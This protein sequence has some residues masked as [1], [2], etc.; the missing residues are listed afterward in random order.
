MTIRVPAAP[1]S[2]TGIPSPAT[3]EATAPPQTQSIGGESMGVPVNPTTAGQPGAPFGVGGHPQNPM[4][5]LEALYQV[6]SQF[7]QGNVTGA[8]P[9]STPL[10]GLGAGAQG[11]PAPSVAKKQK[12]RKG[13]RSNKSSLVAPNG[14]KIKGK[15]DVQRFE[16]SMEQLS[17]AQAKVGGT[18]GKS[19]KL[20]AEEAARV[21]AA[22]DAE[23]AK[24]EVIKI[25][26][27][28]TGTQLSGDA[29]G[30]KGKGPKGGPEREALNQLLGTKIK[31]GEEKNGTSALI[32]D[33]MAGSIADAVRAQPASAALSADPA[34]GGSPAQAQAFSGVR[35]GRTGLD[36]LEC[37]E[38]PARESAPAGG[39]V[40]IDIGEFSDA[41]KTAA[42]LASPLIFDLAG[43]GL[44]LKKGERVMIDL[45]GDGR[46]EMITNLDNGI[47]LLVFD[48]LHEGEAVGSGRDYFG[49]RTDLS[50]YGV[51]SP[52]EDGM[53][54]NGFDALRALCERFELVHGDKQHLDEQDLAFLER[55]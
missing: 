1:V 54:D 5:V 15:K 11:Q 49:D 25:L 51:V 44:E 13:L 55:E 18:S 29:A 47:G 31:S 28:R 21:R 46:G 3:A 22:P 53:W 10:A 34:E 12:P 30:T 19:V 37:E 26:S 48:A 40:E 41:A 8:S 17:G 14:T 2:R 27:E 4:A 38:E 45:D 7:T 43:A 36:D 50:G 39:A 33:R 32:L 6:L 52:R 9:S 35:E 42:E 20:S 16:K 23:S 24:Q